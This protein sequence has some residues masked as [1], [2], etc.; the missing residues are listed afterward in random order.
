MSIKSCPFLSIDNIKVNFEQFVEVAF[1]RVTLISK[2]QCP[3]A[4]QERRATW[5]GPRGQE[6]LSGS[7]GL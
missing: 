1:K 2:V 5:A 7:H 6:V 3:S 4:Q